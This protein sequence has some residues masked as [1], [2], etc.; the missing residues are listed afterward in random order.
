MAQGVTAAVGTGQ[1]DTF[2]FGGVW[3]TGDTYTVLL[4]DATTGV[5]TQVGAG[6]VSGVLAVYVQTFSDKIYVLGGPT[7]YC[8]AVGLP[9]VFNDP[10]A[11][12]NGFV[13]MVNWLS[14]AE[15][16]V[17]VAPYQ[18]RLSFFT[19]RS[20][21]IWA[22]SPLIDNWQ[23]V[24]IL[25]N[26]GTMAPLSVQP[27]G[28]LDVLFLSDTGIRSLRVHDSS[29]NAY[30]DDTGAPIDDLVQYG[31]L[32]SADGG[33]SACAV[34]DPKS[35]RYM[36]YLN[37]VIYVLSYFPSSKIRAWSTYL[38]TYQN[39]DGTQHTITPKKF[40]IYQG[41]VYMLA[42]DA[43][44]SVILRLGGTDNNQY[45]NAT[46][47]VTLPFLDA[48]TPGHWKDSKAIDIVSRGNWT[49]SG[50]LDYIGQEYTPIG[51]VSQ[52]TADTG[53]IDFPGQGTH[54]SLKA[55][56]SDATGAP[57]IPTLSS[58]LWHYEPANETA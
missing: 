10:N 24:Q 37:G 52:V 26:I 8:S 1:D 11:T 27:V 5:T 2:T 36:V 58:V 15:N 29:L 51:T 42:D 7:V 33:V 56:C 46:A 47:T 38:P 49:L 22:V 32:Q 48:K 35:G 43:G 44:D 21:Q 53:R 14:T 45:D 55:T 54:F 18:G 31:L 40:F 50:S 30:V 16:L 25:Q 39:I 12:G 19:R 17:A 20:T 28:D 9:T 57:A 41:Q 4:T 34:V 3:A 6:F 13:S 23:Q